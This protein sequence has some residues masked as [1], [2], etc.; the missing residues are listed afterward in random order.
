MSV[1]REILN[2]ANQQVA[3]RYL[4]LSS[5]LPV[6]SAI[7]LEFLP[8]THQYLLVVSHPLSTVHLPG[9]RKLNL[10]FMQVL[11]TFWAL[12]QLIANLIAW[13][14][15]G[16]FTCEQGAATCTKSENMGWRYYVSGRL[17]FL[18]P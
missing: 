9:P 12:A 5:N 17:E 7:F 14:L 4:P 6:D 18:K 1:E 15:L 16:N 13:P 8:G 3:N 11:S 10:S 2:P